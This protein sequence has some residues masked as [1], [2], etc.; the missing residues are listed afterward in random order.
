MY[1]PIQRPST[2][3]R[4]SNGLTELKNRVATGRQNMAQEGKT[5]FFL[6][7]FTVPKGEDFPGGLLPMKILEQVTSGPS[8]CVYL[9]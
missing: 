6:I 8:Y 5:F 1:E 2:A 7:I 9:C 4:Y 3:T